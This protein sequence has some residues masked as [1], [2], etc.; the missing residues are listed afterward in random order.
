M[1]EIN[2][3]DYDEVPD[4]ANE[5]KLP[6]PTYNQAPDVPADFRTL[7]EAINLYLATIDGNVTDINGEIDNITENNDNLQGE[8]DE[9]KQDIGNV[10]RDNDGSLQH[11]INN[12][13][14]ILNEH[15]QDIE[16][17]KEELDGDLGE[18]YN[19][20]VTAADKTINLNAQTDPSKSSSIS[21]EEGHGIQLDFFEPNKIGI[22]A[23]SSGGGDANFATY[24]DLKQFAAGNI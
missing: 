16:D 8:V 3:R 10:D 24:G 11:Q 6:V 18:F 1:A 23:V 14:P 17:I 21:F 19:I 22:S 5:F 2:N 20:D 9:I 7:A 15:G 12:I 4:S 13:T